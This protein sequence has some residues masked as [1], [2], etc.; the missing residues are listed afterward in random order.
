M[1]RGRGKCRV[2]SCKARNAVVAL[3]RTE[4]APDGNFRYA[5]VGMC[6]HHAMNWLLQ[7]EEKGTY[8]LAFKPHDS[9]SYVMRNGAEPL[10]LTNQ[11]PAT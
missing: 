3:I 8:D 10:R 1:S 11:G 4:R 2:E 6:R 9:Q 5:K 7:L